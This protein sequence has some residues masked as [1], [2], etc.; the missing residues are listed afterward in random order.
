MDCL[1]ATVRPLITSCVMAE[2]EKLGT[3]YRLAL[4][5][6]RDER[7]D[8]LACDHKGVYADDCIVDRSET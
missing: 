8:R 2:L 1:S 6:A 7:W 3:K 4:Q 5:I